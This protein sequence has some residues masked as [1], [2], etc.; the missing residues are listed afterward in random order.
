MLRR[1]IFLNRKAEH[2]SLPRWNCFTNV[3]CPEK[4][5][6]FKIFR[7]SMCPRVPLTYVKM[8]WEPADFS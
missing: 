1:K 4:R 7:Q 2:Y 8:I 6:K 3:Q 5:F